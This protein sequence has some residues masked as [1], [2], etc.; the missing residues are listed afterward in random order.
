M[1]TINGDMEDGLNNDGAQGK[2][3]PAKTPFEEFLITEY[4]NIAQ[5]HFNT[6]NTISTFFRYYLLIVSLPGPL[7]AV[8]MKD[9]PLADVG[10][11]LRPCIPFIIVGSFLVAIVGFFVLWYVCSL[12]FDAILYAR[13]IN[14]VRRFFYDRSGLSYQDEASMRVLPRSTHKPPYVEGTYFLPV[15][16]ALAI[17][18]AAYVAAGFCLLF[19]PQTGTSYS[20]A[21]F[22][23]IC[24]GVVFLGAHVC[25]YLWLA[26]H[27][28]NSY[29]RSHTIGVDIDGVLNC[30]RLHFCRLMKQLRNKEIDPERITKIPVHDCKEVDVTRDDEDAV[31]NHPAYWQDMPVREGAT[32]RLKEL[33]NIF[34]YKILIFTYRPWPNSV[35]FPEPNRAEY[36]ALWDSVTPRWRK[37]K[38]HAI[39]ILTERWLQEKGIPYDGVVIELGNLD[40]LDSKTLARNRFRA[41]R[42]K[43]IRLFAEDDVDKAR[44]LADIC[45]L[46]FLIDHPYN[47]TTDRLPNNLQRVTSWDDLYECVKKVP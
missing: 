44:K 3:H 33:K 9:K 31:F 7:L 46:V 4:S 11:A 23:A 13:T 28:Q 38:D 34:G 1:T 20:G 25:G 12:R 8:A 19:C 42:D 2:L 14:G 40:T 27:W 37:G 26:R 29:L 35:R 24:S 41:S 6:M 17:I 21:V 32:R 5:A 47:Q 10:A 30:H 45:D 18:N 36:E 39:R 16:L 22:A 15:V 43:R